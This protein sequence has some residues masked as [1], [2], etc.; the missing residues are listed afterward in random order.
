MQAV[1]CLE[2][3]LI[4]AALVSGGYAGKKDTKHIPYDRGKSASVPATMSQ[5]TRCLF[6]PY[7]GRN[8][9]T[10]HEV[11]QVFRLSPSPLDNLVTMT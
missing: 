11:G 9:E 6:G 3:G 4:S 10:E 7:R 8:L 2:R 5:P 1:Q